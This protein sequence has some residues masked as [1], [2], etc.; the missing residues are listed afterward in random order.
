M[1]PNTT[2][3]S[4]GFKGTRVRGDGVTIRVSGN[5]ESGYTVSSIQRLSNSASRAIFRWDMFSVVDSTAG[6]EYAV[7]ILGYNSEEGR[8]WKNVLFLGDRINFFPETRILVNNVTEGSQ[9]ILLKITQAP[10]DPGPGEGTEDDGPS[11]SYTVEGVLWDMDDETDY[12]EDAYYR[13][14]WPL[15]IVIR[16]DHAIAEIQQLHYGMVNQRSRMF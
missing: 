9:L 10:G 12:P 11:L 16:K 7:T 1:L 14:Y 4:N 3:Q 8:L 6:E 5:P 2:Q 15:A 13:A